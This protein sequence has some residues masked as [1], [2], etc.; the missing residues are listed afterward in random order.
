[1][2]VGTRCFNGENSVQETM[3]RNQ[4]WH[5]DLVDISNLKRQDDGTTFLLTVIDVFSKQVR[6]APLKNKSAPSL[7]AAFNEV[8][9]D[10]VPT[11]LQID[12]GLEFLNRLC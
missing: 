4:Q 12:K 2:V 7:V 11:T 6:C 5:A 9:V 1:M 3:R 10:V 8:L